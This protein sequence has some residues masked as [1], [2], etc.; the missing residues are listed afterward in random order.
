MQ[1]SRSSPFTFFFLML[2]VGIGTGFATVTLPFIMTRAGFPVATSAS[3]VA[4]GISANIW[5]FVLGPVIDL[6]LSLRRW[7]AIGLAILAS[8]LLLLSLLPL[9]QNG[10]GALTALVFLTMVGVAT[11]G[12]PVGGLMAHTVVLP[13]KGRAGGWNQAGLL[14]GTG[15]GGGAGVWLASH[16]SNAL[17]GAVLFASVSACAVTLYFVPDVR[18]AP[19]EN[20]R[21]RMRQIGRDFRQMIRSPI[22]LF[23]IVMIAAPIGVGAASNLWSAVAPNWRAEPNTVALVAGFLSGF[24]SAVGCVAGGWIADRAGRWWAF[25][26]AGTAMALIAVIIAVGPRTPL[27]FA[28]G[29]LCYA[30]SQGL[31]WAAFTAVM[32]L[33]IGR[34]AAATKFAILASLGNL[35]VVYMTALDGWVHDRSGVDRMLEAEALAAMVC[36]V[37]GLL[38]LR[39]LRAAGGLERE[40]AEATTR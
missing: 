27:A 5:G 17:T 14:G 15:L 13:E 20:L 3:I 8:G 30:F 25:F 4:L 39:R 26:G 18:P 21:Q 2:P 29:V 24:I 23:T 35:P 28:S 19:G 37:V 12:L 7:T 32:L 33:A 16:F 40:P 31:A 34:G 11:T 38:V 9:R 6:T 1:D 36:I 10:V 22:V